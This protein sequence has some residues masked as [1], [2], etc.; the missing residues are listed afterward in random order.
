MP[1][2]RNGSAQPKVENLP[3]SSSLIPVA[4]TYCKL[5][6]CMLKLK[7]VFRFFVDIT[8]ALILKFTR[9]GYENAAL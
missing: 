2:C 3:F 5:V 1:N 8:I 6:I 4:I 7:F 9:Y